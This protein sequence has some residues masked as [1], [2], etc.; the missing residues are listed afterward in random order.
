M[1][2]PFRIT[3]AV[4]PVFVAI[5]CA[6]IYADRQYAF[7]A[8]AEKSASMALAGE[9]YVTGS[10]GGIFLLINNISE[11]VSG[12]TEKGADYVVEISSALKYFPEIN[13][14][15]VVDAS[16]RLTYGTI[17]GSSVVPR[18]ISASERYYFKEIM[19][20]PP[21][22]SKYVFGDPVIGATTGK[23]VVHIAFPVWG[24]GGV[25]SKIIVVSLDTAVYADRLKKLISSRGLES[26][27]LL[28]DRAKIIVRAPNN[29][30]F[31]GRDVGAFEPFRTWLSKDGGGFSGGGR[32]VAPV[33]AVD[34]IV[35][36]RKIPDTPF[37]VLAGIP[38][39]M[40]LSEWRRHAVIE[41]VLLAVVSGLGVFLSIWL[42]RNKRAMDRV[43]ALEQVADRKFRLMSEYATDW[44]FRT[45]MGG[46]D[47]FNSLFCQDITG[48]EPHCFNADQNF[49]STI[50]HRDDRV[51]WNDYQTSVLGADNDGEIE[52]RVLRRDGGVRWISHKNRRLFDESGWFRVGINR[53][54][55]EKKEAEGQRDIYYLAIQQS[56]NAIVIAD[57]RQ[58]IEDVNPAFTEM[59]GVLKEDA[60]GKVPGHLLSTEK[61]PSETYVELKRCLSEKRPWRGTFV[62]R[63]S[64]G[65]EFTSRANIWPIVNS[66]G[67]VVH[68]LAIQEDIS[69]EIAR[70]QELALYRRDLEE[71]TKKLLRARSAA[72]AAS[73]AKSAFLSNMSHE[74]RTP[75]NA[76]VGFVGLMRS[77]LTDPVQIERLQY[78]ETSSHH[79]LA[80]INEILD[81]SKVES[82]KF[83]LENDTFNL[84][85]LVTSAVGQISGLA[86]QKSL[87]FQFDVDNALPSWMNGD[88][89]RLVQCVLN[90]G[91]NA[92]KF[93]ES[94]SVTL[95]VSLVEQSDD[96][97][98]VR[99][100][101]RDTG[102]G[103]KP[104]A[105]A[106]LFSPFEQADNT[107]SRKYG[108]TGLGL[109][110]TR[111]FAELMGGE[112]NAESTVGQGSH[113]WF[114]ARLQRADEPDAVKDAE[115][116]VTAG[117]EGRLL[118]D[119]YSGA[120]LLVVEDVAINR[121]MMAQILAEVG[122]S[123][124]MAENGAVAVKTLRRDAFDLVFMD[125]QMPVMDGLEATSA[126]R[127][128]PGCAQMPIVGLTANAFAE[129]RQRC[130]DAGM[131]DVVVKPVM[132]QVVYNAL[133]KWLPKVEP[134]RVQSSPVVEPPK[135][136][137]GPD[138][139]LT[140]IASIPGIDVDMGLKYVKKPAVYAEFLR[141]FADQYR[142][143]MAE[144]RTHLAKGE[145]DDAHRIAHSLKGSPGMLGLP[146][147]QMRAQKLEAAIGARVA[148]ADVEE[149]T[150]VFEVELAAIVAAIAAM[151]KA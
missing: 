97:L 17:S 87:V 53:D 74:I 146:E 77:T 115:S 138:D 7:T 96:A 86:A 16:G 38:V 47:E 117:D 135:V 122:L 10:L 78:I 5:M 1:F 133:L 84:S 71:Q 64:D 57:S 69:G 9:Q 62:N 14:I 15:G 43:L 46:K 8:A 12:S 139:I 56:P 26:V 73:E 127:A 101:V 128:L 44:I 151:P 27:V 121:K 88:S 19:R 98:L 124:T 104:E 55:T 37:I 100:S 114:T 85:Q 11:H 39:D 93:T 149:L 126:I 70:E 23:R 130:L 30:A 107:I 129:D 2:V 118:V 72:M 75:L 76:I 110:L 35:S 79:L 66:F 136:G 102:I 48:Y 94:G 119:H 82:G 28:N 109:V 45:S 31:F 83:T 134:V 34:K 142:N 36:Y 105:L 147:V 41:G 112:A 24:G 40:A 125:M 18:D 91:S 143:A 137:L 67:V 33:D 120:R 81:L 68:Y 60:I 132:S 22:T 32:L 106:R 89:K 29:E 148:D 50:V 54:I 49:F 111:K 95:A 6:H 92:I 141:D 108:G 131:N 103:I 113:F 59:T 145:R 13:F 21:G 65:S 52:I 51:A 116:P 144:V 25:L 4:V 140:G 63:R 3:I 80:V 58:R 20:L 42:L 123:A 150:I 90:F 99:F 61:T